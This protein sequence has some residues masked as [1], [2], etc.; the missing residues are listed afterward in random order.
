MALAAAVKALDGPPSAGSF[1]RG[2]LGASDLHW[3]LMLVAA[4]RV[5]IAISASAGGCLRS[6]HGP[7][8]TV[9]AGSVTRPHMFIYFHT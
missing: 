8:G 1:L 7:L 6:S 2:D 5:L 3:L 9:V 4:I